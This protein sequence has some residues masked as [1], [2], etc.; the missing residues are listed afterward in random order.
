MRLSTDSS[1]HIFSSAKSES[2]DS[3]GTGGGFAMEIEMCMRAC[4]GLRFQD[5]QDF[6]L[7][8]YVL[9]LVLND[10]HGHNQALKRG[11]CVGE[12]RTFSRRR[13][14][15][16]NAVPPARIAHT[17]PKEKNCSKWRLSESFRLYWDEDFECPG[18]A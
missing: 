1:H 5:F 2:H 11:A 6:L 7:T 15:R 8:S 13:V 12:S 18:H 10:I 3:S 9:F 16:L 4:S 14:W 17:A